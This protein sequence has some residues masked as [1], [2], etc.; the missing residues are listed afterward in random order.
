M[1]RKKSVKISKLSSNP[2][3]DLKTQTFS[4][5]FGT[6][7]ENVCKFYIKKTGKNVKKFGKKFGFSGLTPGYLTVF[8][9]FFLTA[10]KRKSYVIR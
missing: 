8:F 9:Y 2:Q 6:L 4:K 10:L 1:E 5:L 7:H 3:S